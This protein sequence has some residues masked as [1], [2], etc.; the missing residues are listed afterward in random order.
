[1]DFRA[2]AQFLVVFKQTKYVSIIS[3]IIIIS[4]RPFPLHRQFWPARRPT[5]R[6]Q[7]PRRRPSTEHKTPRDGPAVA[8]PRPLIQVSCERSFHQTDFTISVIITI[9]AM[10]WAFFVFYPIPKKLPTSA[11]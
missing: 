4:H 5:A 3:H 7:Q 6:V 8:A 9:T 2:G 10:G 11:E 1:M